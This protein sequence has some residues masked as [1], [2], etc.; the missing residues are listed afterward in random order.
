VD[1][2]NQVNT[3]WKQNKKPKPDPAILQE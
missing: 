2:P 3:W 1:L